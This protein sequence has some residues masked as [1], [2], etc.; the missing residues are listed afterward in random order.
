MIT[1]VF[2][3]GQRLDL[4]DD[5]NISITQGVQDV[6]D[7]SKLFADF[8]QSF[9]VPASKNNNRIFKHYYNQDIDNGFDAR[10]RK[11]AVININ[12]LP[13]KTGKMQLNGVKIK[14]N[15]PSSYKITFFG[16][17]IK[18]KDLIGDDKLNEL[19]W[20][21]N[22]DS[23]YSDV[24]VLE[25]LTTGLDFTVGSVSYPAAVIYPLISYDRQ[26]L[27]NSNVSDVTSTETL[28]NIAY[29][30]GRTDG[31]LFSGLKPAIK[32]SIIVE[33]IQQKY[34][35]NFI[36]GFFES[37]IFKDIYV[38]LNKSTESLA[39]GFLVV[40]NLTTS[41]PLAT[42]NVSNRTRYFVN[43]FP[44]SGFVTVPYGIRVYRDNELIYESNINLTGTSPLQFTN[45]EPNSSETYRFEVVTE[46]NFSF[47]G[48]TD[49]K[50]QYFT[51]TSATPLVSIGTYPNSYSGLSISLVANV[52]NE[53]KDIKTYEF[54]TGLFKTF[55][56]VVTSSGDDILVEDLPSWY[57]Q[58]RI[59]D[60]T[61]YI[62]TTKKDVDKGV[63]F[64][65]IDF[66][67]KESD[68]ILAD[69]FKQ[70][71]NR[72]YGNEELTLYTD[73][74]ETEKLDGTTLDV[75]SEF[76]NPVFERLFN[77]D[78]N[79]LTSVQYCPYFNRS[80]QSISG[81]PFMFYVNSVPVSTNTI[82]FKGSSTYQEVA[83][84]IL[85]PS[86]SQ[87]IDFPSFNLNFAAEINEYTNDVFPDTIYK[88]F[89][90][91]YIG[92]VFS[93]KRRNFKFDSIL[94]LSILNDLKL[95]DRL[96]IKNTRYIINKITSNLTKRGDKLELINDIYS[97]PL[98][99]DVLRTSLFRIAQGFFSSVAQSG[100]AQYVGIKD[101]N[102]TRLDLGFGVSW[103]TV[104]SI[105]KGSIA[106]VSFTLAAN[107]TAS[108]RRAGIQ[109]ND[110]LN[111]P[112]FYVS[113]NESFITVDNNLITVDN[114]IITVDNG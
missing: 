23:E 44:D 76:E 83:V 64:N 69:E 81:S 27:Y 100:S 78:N 41:I 2:I 9:S 84:P 20:L 14:D 49:L 31:V 50:H 101:Q 108:F 92:D 6:K 60:V 10:T 25:G 99:S 63:I 1:Q 103:L 114:N 4:F 72:V 87:D 105:G 24:K 90:S 37:Q 55:N 15:L 106:T 48:T 32:L 11:P 98:V 45:N 86:H 96:V 30:A 47:T 39:N 3:E 88:R 17:V 71:N 52:L 73:S 74:T 28:V 38:N 61:K 79:D 21:S 59:I 66:K 104:N 89:Y 5:E 77:L 7:I 65:E 46:Q 70:S 26:Y 91:D 85:M 62:D 75:E 102:A 58:G 111:N 112:I 29:G 94:P 19:T 42:G 51:P 36:G 18:V 107:N 34:G 80:I 12:T 8:S 113:Q 53:I 57:T 82:G 110:G 33:A 67:F 93:N 109:V 16:D 43:V 40:E 13:F 54:L 22:F 68:Q 56:L 35:F 95:N 97:S